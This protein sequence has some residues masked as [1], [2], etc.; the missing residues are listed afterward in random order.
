MNIARLLPVALVALIGVAGVGGGCDRRHPCHDNG[1]AE[2]G[3]LPNASA[4][5]GKR[6]ALALIIQV[7]L[8][9]TYAGADGETKKEMARVLSFRPMKMRLHESFAEMRARWRSP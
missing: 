6:A 9:M 3:L 2:S 1:L 5:R 8:A 4:S 7:A